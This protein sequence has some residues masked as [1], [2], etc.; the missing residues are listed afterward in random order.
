MP[1]WNG[2]KKR[3]METWGFKPVPTR[4]LT[5]LIDPNHPTLTI[6]QQAQ[7]LG[8][9]R[10]SYYYQP[11]VNEAELARLKL[12]L[13]AIDEIYTA[14]PF[15]G[16]R[17]MRV[18]LEQEYGITIGRER[19]RHLMQQLGL[20]A[21][22]PKPNTSKPTPGHEIYPYLLKGLKIT[23]PNQVWGTDIT[24][25]R[26]TEGFVYLV[27]FMDWYSRYV[28]SW[29][30]SDSLENSFV[31][32]ALQ[33]A[34]NFMA[35]CGL[36]IPA[37]PTIC[38]SDQGSHFTSVAYINLLEQAGVAI[39]MDGRGRCLDNIFTE[40]L[41]RSVKY[42]NVFLQ[43]YQNIQEAQAGLTDYFQFYNHKR[44][45]QS[46][47]YRTPASVYFGLRNDQ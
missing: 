44:K 30:L 6:A 34:L 24:Y 5:A 10:Q 17:R 36:G 12:Q 20:E 1:N 14:Y 27:A 7:L 25:I 40:R 19:I 35:D 47:D 39:S 37:V 29:Q 38:N 21:I 8:V 31:L 42:E 23:K 28:V 32:A 41:W 3:S 26:T 18:E 15:Y 22:Y 16:S 11:V 43:S 4:N 2:L 46:L 13:D 33:E 9:A 45:H